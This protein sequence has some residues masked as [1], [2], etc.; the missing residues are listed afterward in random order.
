MRG[1]I[2][3]TSLLFMT[4]AAM[5][6]ESHTLFWCIQL[7]RSVQAKP[8]EKYNKL[9]IEYA[10]DLLFLTGGSP[11]LYSGDLQN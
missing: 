4:L 1:R 9:C 8:P 10:Y 3:V 11:I 5:R 7:E 2:T 6:A